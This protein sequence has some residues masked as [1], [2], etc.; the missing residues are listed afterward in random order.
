[1]ISAAS[2]ERA[3]ANTL[4][5]SD[6]PALGMKYE[7]KVRDNYT[8]GD[9]RFI[10]VTDRVSAFDHVLGTIP[11]KGQ[12]LNRMAAFWFERTKNI[13]ANHVVHVPDPNVLECVECEALPVEMV[14]RAYATGTTSTSL[15]THYAK[16]ARTFC[17]HTLPDGLQKHQKLPQAILTPATKAAV[18]EHDVSA[19]R[20][21]ILASGK[22]AAADFDQAAKMAMDLF[23]AGESFAK[24]RGLILVD[25][26]YEFGKTKDGRIVVIDEIHTPD[27]SRYWI[28]ASYAEAFAKGEDPPSLDKDYVRRYLTS[29]GYTGDGKPPALPDDVRIEAAKRYVKAF[30]TVTGQEFVPNEEEPSTR[31]LKNV[32]Y[33]IERSRG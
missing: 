16:G 27:S 32:Q 14:V 10:V 22:V 29:V 15:W 7:G 1:M 24:E 11:F 4:G 19:S 21:E 28:Q 13:A 12:L 3:L 20:E 9:R 8:K 2:Y 5:S 6:F 25:T 23:A 31:I 26:K 17:G 18:G 30:E 33:A